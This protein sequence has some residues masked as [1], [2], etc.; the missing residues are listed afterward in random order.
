MAKLGLTFLHC[1]SVRSPVRILT[2]VLAFVGLELNESAK[3]LDTADR[4]AFLTYKEPAAGPVGVPSHVWQS[5]AGPESALF[6]PGRALS[7]I[8]I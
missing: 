3:Q 6:L 8:H 2:R 7:L 4:L 5:G 1:G